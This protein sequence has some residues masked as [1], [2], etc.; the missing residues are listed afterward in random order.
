LSQSS[1]LQRRRRQIKGKEQLKEL[2]MAVAEIATTTTTTEERRQEKELVVSV[3]TIA[4]ATTAKTERQGREGARSR[5][6]TTGDCQQKEGDNK[7]AICNNR[8][9]SNNDGHRGYATKKEI[10]AAVI[11]LGT[12]TSAKNRKQPKKELVVAASFA[13]DS[14]KGNLERIAVRQSSK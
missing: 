5:H 11:E 2:V 9:N 3:V 7:G 8:R 10:V 13:C 6:R 1:E 12:A 4:R 14:S